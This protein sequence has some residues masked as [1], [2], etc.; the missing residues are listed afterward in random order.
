MKTQKLRIKI[1]IRKL[2]NDLI[3]PPSEGGF[4]GARSESGDVIIIYLYPIRY[5]PY[6]VKMWGIFTR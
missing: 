2:H 4:Y 5:M 1:P 6:Q 3:K